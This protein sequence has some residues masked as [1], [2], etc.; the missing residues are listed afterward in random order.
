MRQTDL[1]RDKELR[2]LRNA[3]REGLLLLA[4]WAATLVW[5]VGVCFLYGYRRDAGEIGLVLGMP[6]WTFWGV[7]A[8]WGL[9]LLFS[10]WFCFGYMAD[11]DLGR[12]PEEESGH[13]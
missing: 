13:G 6:D 4:V 1:P 11:D 7:A 10:A 2:L 12:D 5:S 9:C 8:P 3:R